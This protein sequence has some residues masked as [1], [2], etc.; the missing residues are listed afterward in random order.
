MC[1]SARLMAIP[2]ISVCMLVG[3]DKPWQGKFV[4][5]EQNNCFLLQSVEVNGDNTADVKYEAL[6]ESANFECVFNEATGIL[7]ISEL[8]REWALRL[9]HDTL[10]DVSNQD[11]Y[12]FLVKEK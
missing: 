1:L 11:P 8:N 10:F 7:Y 12:C 9:S 6:Q 4:A 3:C 2:L 5:P